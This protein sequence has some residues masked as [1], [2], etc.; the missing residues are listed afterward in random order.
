MRDAHFWLPVLGYYTGARLGELVQLHVA[1]V[2]LNGSV[3][4]IDISEEGGEARGSGSEKSVKSEAGIRKVPIHPDVM[5]LG[6]AAFVAKVAKD[7]RGKRLFWQVGFGADGQASTVFSKW[8]ARLMDKAGLRDPS[9]VFHSFRHTAEDAFRNAL[10]PQYT[11]DRIIGHSGGKVSDG[12]GEG[13]SLETASE[14]LIKAKLPLSLL[15]VVAP[16]GTQ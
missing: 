1:D 8:F 4:Y 16:T 5:A 10:L 11:T 14:A 15:G 3:P 9:L 7:K 13:I 6:F 2:H 12:Y